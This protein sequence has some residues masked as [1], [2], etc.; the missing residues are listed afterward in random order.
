M[1]YPSR[2]RSSLE[3]NR[4]GV[5]MALNET[6]N[7]MFKQQ[8]FFAAHTFFPSTPHSSHCVVFVTFAC[9]RVVQ[10]GC[11]L[12]YRRRFLLSLGYLGCL[13]LSWPTSTLSTLTSSRGCHI[14]PNSDPVSPHSAYWP[15]G[16]APV[17]GSHIAAV[18]VSLF[19]SRFHHANPPLTDQH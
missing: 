6:S 7:I 17:A 11:E 3:R 14:S 12:L 16:V 5:N 15:P 8:C 18:W 10:V 9:H 4:K 19:A 13:F 1:D 2:P